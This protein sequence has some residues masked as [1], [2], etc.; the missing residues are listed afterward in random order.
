MCRVTHLS[1]ILQI[2]VKKKGHIAYHCKKKVILHITVK[3][4]LQITVKG[5]TQ[6][7]H[8]I[9]QV[10][11]CPKGLVSFI[12]GFKYKPHHNILEVS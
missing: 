4:I 1:H 8:D 2:A 3:V 6:A 12:N 9:S 11:P 7:K 5:S 10:S